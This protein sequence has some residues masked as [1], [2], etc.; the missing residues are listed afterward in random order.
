MA[1]SSAKVRELTGLGDCDVIPC[2][3]EISY[4]VREGQHSYILHLEGVSLLTALRFVLPV[5]RERGYIS[6]CPVGCSMSS[7][8]TTFL[9]EQGI[10]GCYEFKL[11]HFICTA[12]LAAFEDRHQ[13]HTG[14]FAQGYS[15]FLC[16]QRS[17]VVQ[18]V[19]VRVDTPETCVV[20]SRSYSADCESVASGYGSA[21]RKPIAAREA[22]VHACDAQ[23]PRRS[24]ESAL[25]ALGVLVRDA[26]RAQELVPR[27]SPCGQCEKTLF[28]EVRSLVQSTRWSKRDTGRKASGR[29][30]LQGCKYFAQRF[31]LVSRFHRDLELSEV[32]WFSICPEEISRHIGRRI[33]MLSRKLGRKIRILDPF[34]GAGG[35]I[36]QAALM[37][38]VEHAWAS[39]IDDGEVRCAERMAKLY[40]AEAKITFRRSDVFDLDPRTLASV[41]AIVTSPPWGGP[42]YL[43]GIYDLSS[44]EPGYEKMLSHLAQ[45]TANMAI[46]MPRNVAAD[47]VARSAAAAKSSAAVELEL[48]FLAG[49][50]KTATVYYG[51]L[52]N[53]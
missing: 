2:S 13:G 30:D 41:D 7:G 22:T 3:A 44:M 50:P 8:K 26:G 48:N 21:A 5:L 24:P 16:G 40:E 1:R 23:Q 15:Y 43:Q 32:A 18:R 12:F 46:L 39:D 45:F 52:V 29:N 38:E 28:G 42:A 20:L 14:R 37:E 51:A 25:R 34:C 17:P 53:H 36:V 6:G 10:P 35:N 33:A 31:R 9:V 19:V 11:A 4:P 47:Q 27:V 49:K